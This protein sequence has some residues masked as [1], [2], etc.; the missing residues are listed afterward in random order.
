MT[1]CVVLCLDLGR[2]LENVCWWMFHAIASNTQNLGRSPAPSRHCPFMLHKSF[3]LC[4]EE[5][6]VLSLDNEDSCHGKPTTPLSPLWSSTGNHGLFEGKLAVFRETIQRHREGAHKVCTLEFQ[7][8]RRPWRWLP[9]WWEKKQAHWC[10][11]STPSPPHKQW[12][13]V[14]EWGPSE[15]HSYVWE[16]RL[17]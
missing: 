3:L 15:G 13:D 6:F 2:I 9:T 1:A 12:V 17:L 8:S 4:L 7:S 5:I 16:G 11:R 10:R 14:V